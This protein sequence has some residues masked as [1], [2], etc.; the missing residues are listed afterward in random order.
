MQLKFSKVTKRNPHDERSLHVM[1]VLIK[2]N[3]RHPERGKVSK[4]S[5][6]DTGLRGTW[7]LPGQ[8]TGPGH[9]LPRW[10][11]ALGGRKLTKP[12]ECAVCTR[13]GKGEERLESPCRPADRCPYPGTL[14]MGLPCVRFQEFAS[15]PPQLRPTSS[16]FH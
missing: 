3:T 10:L 7:A 13:S 6:E 14:T 8:R 1:R 9:F 4:A 2:K 16:G 5:S 12:T 11:R 15:S